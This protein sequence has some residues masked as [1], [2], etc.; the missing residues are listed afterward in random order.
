MV[1][2]DVPLNSYFEGHMSVFRRLV[3][4]FGVKE[5]SQYMPIYREILY[6]NLKIYQPLAETSARMRRPG[7]VGI[8]AS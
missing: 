5:L 2:L 8:K 3:F 1:L 7:S 4:P 6:F